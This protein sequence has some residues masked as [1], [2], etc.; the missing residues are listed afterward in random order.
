MVPL[1]NFCFIPTTQAMPISEL[2][3]TTLEKPPKKPI[4]IK[5]IKGFA[6]ENSYV[7]ILLWHVANSA[8]FYNLRNLFKRS[9]NFSNKYGIN[10]E[11]IEKTNTIELKGDSKWCYDYEIIGDYA[12]PA[13]HTYFVY[14]TIDGRLWR[15][16]EPWPYPHKNGLPYYRVRNL[17]KYLT[18]GLDSRINNYH[19]AAIEKALPNMFLSRQ[20]PI[21][22]IELKAQDIVDN[23]SII[24]NVLYDLVSLFN[25]ISGN[26]KK[27]KKSEDVRKMINDP[28]TEYLISTRLIAMY[29]KSAINSESSFP[30]SELIITY[31]NDLKKTT[32]H[33]LREM[34]NY[35][36]RNTLINFEGAAPQRYYEDMIKTALEYVIS[37]KSNIYQNMQYKSFMLD[38]AL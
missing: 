10:E 30:I 23:I 29:K 24:R 36:D 32:R 6:S 26:G 31:L 28:R 9:V 5:D 15:N 17:I 3:S 37:S 2:I 7:Y 18:K 1:N 27:I 35:S 34:N 12:E 14:E 11:L 33:I 21:E 16:M 25:K 22:N 19:K 13:L 8:V 20:M 38:F 4:G